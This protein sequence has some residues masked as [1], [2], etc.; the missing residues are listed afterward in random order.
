MDLDDSIDHDHD[1]TMTK[2]RNLRDFN[3]RDKQELDVRTF[4]RR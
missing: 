2:T 4:V 3:L 1:N